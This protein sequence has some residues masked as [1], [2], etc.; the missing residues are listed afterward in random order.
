M[1]RSSAAAAAA[2]TDRGFLRSGARYGARNNP[3]YTS[4][5][6]LL[7]H[8]ARL[9]EPR[10]AVTTRAV[11]VAGLRSGSLLQT[12]LRLPFGS[13][14]AEAAL[15]DVFVDLLREHSESSDAGFEVVVTFN[16]VLTNATETTFSLFYGQD[17]RASN[18]AGAAPE[19]RYGSTHRVR[20]LLEVDSLPTSFDADELVRAHRHAFENSNVH[21]Y[22]FLN[23]VY[24]VYSFLE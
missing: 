1:T 12:T 15:R 7:S 23:V 22:A 20:S 13:P 14:L 2:A 19:L 21:I 4:L 11:R 5:S 3:H 6:E 24:L 8:H 16:A 17:H 9:L 18:V 10:P